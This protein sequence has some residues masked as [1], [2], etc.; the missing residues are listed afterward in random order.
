MIEKGKQFF[1]ALR[2]GEFTDPRTALQS[3]GIAGHQADLC[4]AGLDD[5]PVGP[6]AYEAQI[7]GSESAART[8]LVLART[9]NGTIEIC[10]GYIDLIAATE[11]DAMMLAAEGLVE[12]LPP[13]SVN[14]P[15]ELRAFEV[16]PSRRLLQ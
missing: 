6:V 12:H 2:V 5:F 3:V 9:E 1:P 16:V 10:Y 15:V 11:L 13:D 8:V 7:A 4:V 14:E